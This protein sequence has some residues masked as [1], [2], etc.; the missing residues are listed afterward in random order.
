MREQSKGFRASWVA[1]VTV[2]ILVSASVLFAAS[3]YGLGG[4][5]TAAKTETSTTT[6]AESPPTLHSVTFNETGSGCTAGYVYDS[7]VRDYGEHHQ[8][9][10]IQRDLP[11]SQ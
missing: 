3:P 8:R 5:K 10:T 7:M 4:P 1:V 9:P 6:V 11:I 2:A